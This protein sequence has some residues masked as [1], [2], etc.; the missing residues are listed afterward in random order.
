MRLLRHTTLVAGLLVATCTTLHAAA[1]APAAPTAVARAALADR[2][3]MQAELQA[4]LELSQQQVA[5]LQKR[6]DAT[7]D[8]A[9]RDALQRHIESAKREGE[10]DLVRIQ[11][12]HAQ[13]SGRAIDAKQLQAMLD[14]A[15]L[16]KRAPL[17]PLPAES[18][19]AVPRPTIEKAVAK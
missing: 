1:S 16:E 18:P 5:A 11:L 3:A 17:P 2:A 9:L 10:L 14:R 6:A 19:R 15:A 12:R 8:L 4:R 7:T 13:A